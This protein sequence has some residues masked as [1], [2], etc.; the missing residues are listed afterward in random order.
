MVVL[1][2]LTYLFQNVPIFSHPFFKMLD[3]I[4]MP[5]I[6]ANR[7]PQVTHLG[8]WVCWG[9]QSCLLHVRTSVSIQDWWM[10]FLKFGQIRVCLLLKTST[11]TI[12]LRLLLSSKRN[13]IYPQVNSF[14]FVRQLSPH[15]DMKPKQHVFYDLMTKDPTSTH[16]I[17]QFAHLFS[18]ATPSLH[19]K[20]A[21]IK[22][23]GIMR[24]KWNKSMLY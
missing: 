8:F 17:S 22:D 13:L 4:I 15:W 5:F 11:L 14:N 24:A 21:W 3:S 19:I 12:I 10:L 7:P 23:T 1:P 16:L 2:K 20:E 9:S 18:L 6:W